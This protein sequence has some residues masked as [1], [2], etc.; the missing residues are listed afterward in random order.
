MQSKS[1]Q[2]NENGHTD[3]HIEFQ[4]T[5]LVSIE[6]L[7][8]IQDAFADANQVASTITDINGVPITRPSNHCGVCAL[9]RGSARGRENC[10]I[11]GKRL[12]SMATTSGKPVQRSCLGVGFTDAAAP[13][14]VEGKHIANWLIGQYHVNDVTAGRVRQYAREIAVDEDL[15]AEAFNQM[16]KL[17]KEDFEKKLK[18]LDIMANE[19]SLMG[20]NQLVSMRRNDELR[21]I[22]ERLEGYQQTLED[23]VR[24][25]TRELE[26]LNETLQKEIHISRKAQQE[27]SKLL[28]AIEHVAEGIV[29]TDTAGRIVYVNPALET[30]T[31]YPASELIDNNP[32]ILNSGFHDAEF[33]QNFWTTISRGGVWSGRV[34]NRKKDGTVYQE[35]TTA[36]SVKDPTGKIVN[37]VAVKRD[38]TK[39]LEMEQQFQQK[40]KLEAIGTLAAGVA[41]EINTPVQ[42]VSDNTRFVSEAFADIMG[43]MSLEQ[44]LT[45]RIGNMGLFEKERHEISTF[46][47]EIDLEFLKEE[48]VNAIEASLEGLERINSIVKAMKDFTHPGSQEKTVEQLDELIRSTVNVSRNEWKYEADIELDLDEALPPV[49]VLAGPLKQVILNLIINATHAV[50]EKK[51]RAQEHQGKGLI[52]IVTMQGGDAAVI[53][54][55]DNGTGIPAHIIDKVFDP[56]FT[57]KT[58]GTGTG[59]GLSLAYTT[60][61]DGH[62]GTITVESEEGIGTTFTIRLPLR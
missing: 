36:S 58:V 62:G 42:Y 45:Q 39:E 24:E 31:G 29:I 10:R 23:K 54:I 9:I 40:S 49:F 38:I 7:Q 27:Q 28:T 51:K 60:I 8:T 6:K 12:G 30:M 3:H 56:F 37:Y 21:R 50:A 11:S 18:F 44:D 4:L 48:T 14:I 33:F 25:R 61:V 35:E 55:E 19:I 20:Y 53:V 41:H 34:K 26:M 32:R 59:Q 13:I 2:Q 46:I 5:D 52:R 17:T 43:L 1:A 16:P 47:E 57:T 15:L 22:Q